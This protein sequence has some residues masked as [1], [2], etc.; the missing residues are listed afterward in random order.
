MSEELID[1]SW[2]DIKWCSFVLADVMNG[3]PFSFI[4]VMNLLTASPY[5]ATDLVVSLRWGRL[6][7]EL[8]SSDPVISL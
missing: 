5:S 7:S 2:P 6:A 1:T 3:L 8:A 4:N